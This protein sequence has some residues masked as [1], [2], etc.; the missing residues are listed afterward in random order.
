MK[1]GVANESVCNKSLE[2]IIPT[3]FYGYSP[4]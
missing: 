1:I 2:V 4:V 3:Q